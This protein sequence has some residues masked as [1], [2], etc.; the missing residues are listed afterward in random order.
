VSTLI[1]VV[2]DGLAIAVVPQLTLPRKSATVVGVRLENTSITRTIGMVRR[3]GR[4][5]RQPRSRCC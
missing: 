1:G 3:T 5:P 4:Y 2:K